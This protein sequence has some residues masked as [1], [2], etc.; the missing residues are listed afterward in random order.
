MNLPDPSLRRG[1]Q[2]GREGSF[3]PLGDHVRDWMHVDHPE[4]NGTNPKLVPG[5]G[6]DHGD[7]SRADRARDSVGGH[8][9]LAF[10]EDERLLVGMSVLAWTL[11]DAEAEHEE[12]DAGAM[13]R[14]MEGGDARARGL[15]R[16]EVDE[17]HR[18]P[19]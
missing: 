4:R 10:E 19:S 13:F 1:L 11:A 16:V 2:L 3:G 12:R 18:G 14:S 5:S 17:F 7:G 6:R 8:V 9:D 15:D